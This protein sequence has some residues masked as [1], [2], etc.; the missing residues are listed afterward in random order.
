VKIKKIIREELDDFG[1]ARDV[2]LI[3]PK[4]K[5]ELWHFVG[6]SF[7]LEEDHFLNG[8]WFNDSKTWKITRIVG[9]EVY[10]YNPEDG[11]GTMYIGNFLE[12]INSGWYVLVSPE[13]VI[14][15]PLFN[16]TYTP[17]INESEDLKWIQ[18]IEPDL[19][20][21]V[22][23]LKEGL[24]V[25]INTNKEDYGVFFRNDLRYY[26]EQSSGGEGTV[27]YW[28]TPDGTN[29]WVNV[30]WDNGKFNTYPLHEEY[31]IYS[32][33]MVIDQ[34]LI[35]S[36]EDDWAWARG[37]ILVDEVNEGDRIRI[38]NKGEEEAFISWL[39]MYSDEYLAGN[40]GENIE[41]IVSGVAEDEFKLEVVS[42]E[43]FEHSIYF[44]YKKHME[45]IGMSN[46]DYY[47][48]G[49]EYELIPEPI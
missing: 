21:K 48:L 47:G 27:R 14:F 42:T 16:R 12:H 10:Y 31:G 8:R 11:V 34:P 9:D 24:R 39:G 29:T 15:D 38:H 25:K 7:L 20:V 13:G 36:E 44:P 45:Y 1:W 23:D 41:G 46:E 32:L 2:S 26:M 19:R 40:Y 33:L 30:K 6:W 5:E 43:G 4:T 28:S 37:P 49:L 18:D 3:L 35:E 22:S 17:K